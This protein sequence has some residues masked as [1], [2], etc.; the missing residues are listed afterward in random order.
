MILHYSA[1]VQLISMRQICTGC[2][3]LADYAGV[4][5]SEDWSSFIDLLAGS[6]LALVRARV[7]PIQNTEPHQLH[8]A[9]SAV[10]H[11]TARV[12]SAPGCIMQPLGRG[13]FRTHVTGNIKL[14]PQ[15]IR[16]MS[17]RCDLTCVCQY[18]RYMAVCSLF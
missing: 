1:R 5:E 15:L 2:N 18:R 14:P 7:Q 8:P 12:T 4:A 3:H 16:N 10:W 13:R 6:C 9:A 17:V 11:A